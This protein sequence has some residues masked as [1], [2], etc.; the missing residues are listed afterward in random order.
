MQMRWSSSQR[1]MLTWNRRMEKAARPCLDPVSPRSAS[2]CIASCAANCQHSFLR[3]HTDSASRLFVI[4]TLRRNS[5][6]I[7][8]LRWELQESRAAFQADGY[9]AVWLLS[10]MLCQGVRHL[11]G[12]G[13][14]G[15]REAAAEDEGTRPVHCR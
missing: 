8:F 11:H 14:G 15:Q 9:T 2:T 1:R 5:R 3:R 10:A 6:T 12:D 13:C 4:K 7:H